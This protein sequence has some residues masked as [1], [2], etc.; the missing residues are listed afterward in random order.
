MLANISH[1]QAQSLLKQ[2][3]ALLLT[4]MALLV[5]VL[6]LTFVA[7][8]KDREL[9]L[10]PSLAKPLTI[11]SASISPEYLEMVTRD[12]ATLALNRSPSAL[13]YWMEGVLKIVHPSAY[14]RVKADL[15]KLVAEQRGSDVAQSFTFTGM[16]IYP[17]TLTSDVSGT[18]TTF[19]GK[20]VISSEPKVFR[21]VWSYSGVSL[22][23]LRFGLVEAKGAA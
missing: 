8:S 2:R 6:S 4:T 1:A 16:K 10:V 19:V 11:S 14:G 12:V 20:Q 17:R 9:V 13:D 15:M 23:L 7:T 21:F 5:V 3:N 18:L 22:S